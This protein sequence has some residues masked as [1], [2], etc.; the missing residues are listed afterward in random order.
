MLAVPITVLLEGARRPDYRQ[1]VSGFSHELQ[2]CRQILIA[3][4]ARNRERGQTAEISDATQRI[5]E[6][7]VGFEVGVE[8]IGPEWLRGCDEHIET[9]E[10]QLHPL[11]QYASHLKRADVVGPADL[12]VDVAVG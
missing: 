11:L 10:E 4:P 2:S 3:K 7:K 1:I 8:R 6:H 9:V 5:G 12:F